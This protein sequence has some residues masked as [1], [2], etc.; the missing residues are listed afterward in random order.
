LP[1]VPEPT[2]S[3]TRGWRG[4]P[5]LVVAATVAFGALAACWSVLAPLGEAPDEPA[6]LALVLHLA[7][8]H[9][10]PRY[11]GLRNQVAI[12][13]LCRTYASAT[14]ACPR[15]GEPVTR[16]S[17]RRHPRE[18][19]PDKGTRPAW[20][21][22]GGDA[23]VGQLN[24]MPQHPPLYYEAMAGV[25]RVERAVSGHPW[26]T[27]RELALLRLANALLIAP[28][29]LLA[30]WGARRFGAD[31]RAAAAA[32][33]AP[34]ALPMLTH[35]GSTLNNDN[36][37]TLCGAALAALLAGV[38][39]G[40]HSLRTAVAVG[41]VTAAALLTKAF[42]IGFP[43]LVAVAYL[44]GSREA[45]AGGSPAA[46]PGARPEA[47]P[48][49]E[50]RAQATGDAAPSWS[51][52]LVATWRPLAVAAAVVAVGAAW[53]YVHVR[54]DTGRFAPTIESARLTSDLR[55]PGFHADRGA[56]AREFADQLTNRFWGSF[57]WYTVRFSSLLARL[58]TAVAAG[59]VAVALVPRR[60]A[61]ANRAQRAFLLT[62]TAVL[63]AF[64]VAR[65]WDLYS[66]SG[67]YQF[68][69]GRYLFAGVGAAAILVGLGAARL[70][71]RW[72]APAVAVAAALVQAQGL[73][74]CLADW[75]GGPHLGPRG[76]LR[77]M[78]AWSAWPGEL[79]VALGVATLLVAGWLV[80]ELVRHALGT[81]EGD[82]T[83]GDVGHE[84]GPN[85]RHGTGHVPRGGEVG[86]VGSAPA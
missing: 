24:Q 44:L 46:P 74:R 10:Y 3:R 68:I 49:Q 31:D 30:W 55:P 22:E 51:D 81:T 15:Q 61:G 77:A 72:A 23:A 79:V 38:V 2:P 66:T 67:Q 14:R 9:G 4:I 32:A 25:L 70:V 62:P 12:I 11:D 16:T 80:A 84:A 5:A 57:G 39:R 36:L 63:G 35:I 54:L 69:Q 18:E 47:P 43:P 28:L 17:M 65:A 40:D 41:L 64:V 78:V 37:L 48:G 59:L 26:S 50:V 53:W 83:E 7:D 86:P 6:H 27:D 85:D 42:A 21:D 29:P 52:R 19:A 33:L 58:C 71:G 13:R 60:V 45:A 1:A 76:Q 82:G 34:F 75:W 73:R 20:D 56:F 8:G